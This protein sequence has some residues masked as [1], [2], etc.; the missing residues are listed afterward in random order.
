MRMIPPVIDIHAPYGEKEI[1]Q[2]LKTTK[3]K[4]F[5]NCIVFHSLNYPQSTKKTSQKI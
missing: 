3:I 5:D 4:N 2:L 1:F